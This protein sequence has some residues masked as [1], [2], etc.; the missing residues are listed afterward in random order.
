[1]KYRILYVDKYDVE[2]G[3]KKGDV[4][5]GELKTMY[6]L[7]LER[8]NEV[9]D[10]NGDFILYKEQVEEVKEGK[11]QL[12]SQNELILAICEA[13]EMLAEAED[14]NVLTDTFDCYTNGIIMGLATALGMDKVLAEYGLETLIMELKNIKNVK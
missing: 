11:Y 13:V 8:D 2:N 3:F 1:M 14:N 4:V 9:I 5:E 10:V 7:D 12:A 6:D